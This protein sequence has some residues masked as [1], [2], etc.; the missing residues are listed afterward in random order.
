MAVSVNVVFHTQQSKHGFSFAVYHFL[1]LIDNFEVAK[2]LHVVMEHTHIQHTFFDIST[3]Y[4]EVFN[5]LWRHDV[6]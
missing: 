2:H 4:K 5:F 6:M 3:I 1:L